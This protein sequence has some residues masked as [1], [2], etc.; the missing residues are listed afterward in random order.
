MKI[1]LNNDECK[2]PRE[3]LESYLSKQSGTDHDFRQMK[4]AESNLNA[5][6]VV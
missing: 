4:S 1:E 5:E 3:V 6:N 2:A